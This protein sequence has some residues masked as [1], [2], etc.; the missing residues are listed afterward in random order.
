M[1][2]KVAR[3]Q[4]WIAF[5]TVISVIKGLNKSFSYTWYYDGK[6]H[7]EREIFLR[8]LKQL[9][10]Q[11]I[12]L[13]HKLIFSFCL[14]LCYSPLMCLCACGYA[15]ARAATVYLVELP[16]SSYCQWKPRKR[17]QSLLRCQE[18]NTC[19]VCV[20]LWELDTYTQ[21][22]CHFSLPVLMWCQSHGFQLSSSIPHNQ[23]CI[24]NCFKL[25]TCNPRF[26]ELTEVKWLV[27]ICLCLL[28]L[29]FFFTI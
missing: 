18:W 12:S 11:L 5:T 21:T 3:L 8:D 2:M 1:E 24:F 26:A 7:W 15:T 4:L 17:S 10:R 23:T 9:Q 27:I 14:W 28:C 6:S 25:S 29:W 13:L 22:L 16:I 19:C 20:G